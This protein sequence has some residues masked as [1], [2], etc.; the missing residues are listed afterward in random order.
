M[1]SAQRSKLVAMLGRL[2]S[3]FDGERSAAGYLASRFLVS[4]SADWND[5]IVPATSRS[6]VKSRAPGEVPSSVREQAAFILRDPSRLKAADVS[7]LRTVVQQRRPLTARQSAWL[8]DLV[9]RTTGAQ[10]K[11]GAAS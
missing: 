10:S 5:V 11:S 2:G 7:F 4:I 6:N 8:A 1:T 9:A 3:S